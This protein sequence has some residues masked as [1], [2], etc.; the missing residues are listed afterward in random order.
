MKFIIKHYSGT[1]LH[2]LEAFLNFAAVIISSLVCFLVHRIGRMRV[3]TDVHELSPAEKKKA[4]W[5]E[6]LIL[7][8]FSQLKNTV[9][10][11]LGVI[12]EVLALVLFLIVLISKWGVVV[13]PLVTIYG[14]LYHLALATS[15]VIFPLYQIIAVEGI[16]EQPIALNVLLT[17]SV[18]LSVFLTMTLLISVR[19][20]STFSQLDYRNTGDNLERE[21]KLHHW[22]DIISMI[23][24]FYTILL[25][26][27]L[28]SMTKPSLGDRESVPLDFNNPLEGSMD[29][30]NG[31]YVQ[32][33]TELD[34]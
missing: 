4:R 26:L 9:V 25:L 20:T 33:R 7:V 21:W 2:L 3:I 12:M 19:F 22:I 11:M 18:G 28:R 27:R 10:Q 15:L 24:A 1:R 23:C 14:Y 31:G 17:L 8:F 5:M 6:R 16:H 34:I 29:T 13:H 32:L 30:E